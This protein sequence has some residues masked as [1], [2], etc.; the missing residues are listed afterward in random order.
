MTLKL[1]ALCFA[2]SGCAIFQPVDPDEVKPFDP[3][4]EVVPVTPFRTMA[5]IEMED[6]QTLR[7]FMLRRCSCEARGR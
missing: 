1:F 3:K 2:L 7:E 5:C 4:W 6:V